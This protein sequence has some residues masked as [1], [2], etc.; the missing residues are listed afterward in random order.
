M[1]R[2][3]KALTAA[4]LTNKVDS[5]GQSIGRRYA[6]ADELGTPFGVT[7]D[8]E[9]LEEGETV[10]LRDRDTAQQVSNRSPVVL[11]SKVKKFT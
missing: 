1:D 2:V 10:T 9:T 6:R 11:I 8:F 5:T 3:S 7:I 4:G